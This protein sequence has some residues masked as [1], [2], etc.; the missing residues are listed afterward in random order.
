M[1]RAPNYTFS[2]DQ[3]P[4]DKYTFVSSYNNY[5]EA[6]V[7]RLNNKVCYFESTQNQD[8]GDIWYDAWILTPKEYAKWSLYIILASMIWPHNY[9]DF[10]YNGEICL[11][12]TN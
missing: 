2:Y 5:R 10:K 3:L 11:K 6:G 12:K 9:F 8:T 7:C 1:N 4:V